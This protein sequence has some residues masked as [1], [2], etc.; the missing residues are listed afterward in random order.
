M[1]A[2]LGGK[3]HSAPRKNRKTAGAEGSDDSQIAARTWQDSN[4]LMRLMLALLTGRVSI[5]PSSAAERG[6]A[7]NEGTALPLRQ[8]SDSLRLLICKPVLR[9]LDRGSTPQGSHCMSATSSAS[10]DVGAADGHADGTDCDS[11]S[12]T[13]DCAE[14]NQSNKHLDLLLMFVQNRRD[15]SRDFS[16]SAAPDAERGPTM[17]EL[18]RR[19][20]L[21]GDETGDGLLGLTPPSQFAALAE[22][23]HIE[24]LDSEAV[25][26]GKSSEVL[27]LRPT[28]SFAGLQHFVSVQPAV[29]VAL[30]HL[31]LPLVSRGALLMSEE[32]DL[33]NRKLMQR[34]GEL[35]AR[36]DVQVQRLQRKQMARLHQEFTQPLLEGRPLP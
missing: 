28:L 10:G 33:T 11:D 31:F 34:A 17:R 25:T 30:V 23:L 4:L 26:S 19:N 22:C 9:E 20:A 2:L 35:R 13:G 14:Q 32:I 1:R 6:I 18:S 27:S 15:K 12:N 21:R 36:M 5:T 7:D 24:L 3:M 8:F 29:F 16:S